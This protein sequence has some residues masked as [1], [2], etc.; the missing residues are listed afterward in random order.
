MKNVLRLRFILRQPS[1]QWKDF[2]IE[3]IKIFKTSIQVNKEK[4]VDGLTKKSLLYN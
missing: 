3:D 2:K 1:P 4:I